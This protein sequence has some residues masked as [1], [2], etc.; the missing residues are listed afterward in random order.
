MYFRA[1][2][3]SEYK[4]P[5]E[6]LRLHKDPWKCGIGHYTDV[7][8][9]RWDVYGLHNGGSGRTVMARRI[10]DA[11]GYYSTETNADMSG[12][13]RWIPYKVEVIEKKTA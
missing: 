13:H 5:I 3:L 12:F 9:V 1:S 10:N 2:W 7:D 11:P 6:T 4:G 8:G